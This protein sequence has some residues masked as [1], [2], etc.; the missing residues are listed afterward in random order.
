MSSTLLA[1]ALL[2]M[3][4][5]SLKGFV[6]NPRST[7]LSRH[8]YLFSPRCTT[9]R[10]APHYWTH[11]SSLS[12]LN[13]NTGPGDNKYEEEDDNMK[14]D[15]E[16]FRET[17]DD[18]QYSSGGMSGDTNAD[19][20]DE[21]DLYMKRAPSEFIESKNSLESALARAP[22][23]DWGGALET[24]SQRKS[25]IESGKSDNPSYAIFRTIAMERP[26]EAIGRFVR[27]ANPEVVASMSGAVSSLLGGLSSPAMGIETVVQTSSEKLGQLCFQLMMT[28][29]MF[30]NAEYVIALKNLMNIKADA[31]LQEYEAAF[32]KL[33]TNNSGYLE[34][35]EVEAMLAKVYE[36]KTPT[37]EVDTFMEFFDKNNDGSEYFMSGLSWGQ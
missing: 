17:I 6:S 2:L 33:D 36:G 7:P 22:P 15:D 1:F 31:T 5:P 24:L 16:L 27:E 35:N 34:W 20:D 32:K 19:D 30:R 26:N 13:A 37:F 8:P 10:Y 4:I 3:E 21:E 29:Y 14:S 11:Q 12:A 25:D 18:Q 23:V 9:N 28:G